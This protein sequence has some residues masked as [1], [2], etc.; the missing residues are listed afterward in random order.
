MSSS[1][2]LRPATHAEW[3][4]YQERIVGRAVELLGGLVEEHGPD[5]A[6]SPQS[7][8]L[9]LVR[10]LVGLV[11]EAGGS[12]ATDAL[13]SRLRRR[14]VE[15]LGR[16]ELAVALGDLGFRIQDIVGGA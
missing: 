2:G 8:E 7:P 5:L 13:R 6:F 1:R 14:L 12:V 16:E 3:V 15:V 9:A 4:H 10:N 11:H